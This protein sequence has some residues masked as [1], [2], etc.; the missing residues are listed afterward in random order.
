[1][2]HPIHGQYTHRV[3]RCLGKFDAGLFA[4]IVSLA[5]TLVARVLQGGYHRLTW[6]KHHIK[7]TGCHCVG[8]LGLG[9]G[10]AEYNS[11]SPLR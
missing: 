4:K 7:E 9:C 11:N 3:V 10:L 5:A 8:L 1:M 6:G 2:L